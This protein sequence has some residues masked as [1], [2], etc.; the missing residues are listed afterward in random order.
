MRRKR[1]TKHQGKNNLFLNFSETGE[2]PD[3]LSM[4][5]SISSE[6]EDIG[7]LFEVIPDQESLL[8]LGEFLNLGLEEAALFSVLAE[9]SLQEDVT[10]DRLAAF[11]K[12]KGVRVLSL[13]EKIE[14]MES[15]FLI[16]RKLATEKRRQ[17]YRDISFTVPKNVMEAL[18]TGD[19]RL[20]ENHQKLSFTALLDLLKEAF[21]ERENDQIT[22]VQFLRE[23][24]DLLA[25]GR[26]LP[27]IQYLNAHLSKT[28]SKAL[29]LLLVL[30]KVSGR[31]DTPPEYFFGLLFP[32]LYDQIEFSRN[33]QNGR[34]ELVKTGVV[35]VIGSRNDNFQLVLGPGAYK[36]LFIDFPE[37][38]TSETG[39]DGLKPHKTI[40]EK[41]LYFNAEVNERIA[42]LEKLL[43]HEEFNRYK[44]SAARMGM[45]HGITT[46]FYGTPGTGKTELALQIARKTR[47]DLMMID[48]SQTRSMW[49]GESEKQVRRI[50]ENYR[51]ALKTSPAEPIL[52]INEADGLLSHRTD[53]GRGSHGVAHTQ[54]LIQN[55]LLEELENFRDI[56]IATTNLTG[57]LDK[58]FERRF[59]LKIDFPRPD[60]TVRKQIWLSKLPELSPA[61][62]ES[63][64]T[65]F[66]FSGGQIDNQVKQL[67]MK[68][69]LN[70]DIDLLQTLT[71]SCQN[72]QGFSDRK[73][74]GYQ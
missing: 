41:K 37:L 67:L 16:K 51:E 72:E 64:A 63:L 68:R 36:L 26:S 11:F 34:H 53:L 70:P 60:S 2:K 4:I 71:E 3:Y 40:K 24:E 54:N 69:I 30:F 12:C 9:L 5:A 57:N 13:L 18:R 35:K 65:Q 44:E 48:L 28:T 7:L 73:R 21:D 14:L 74:I 49:F 38:V 19:P 55:I 1:S 8:S 50:F 6:A 10:L 22:T 58:A 20:L 17:A 46:I 52:F 39:V 29:A 25:Q 56:L 43:N 59:L 15:R 23:V 32:K 47:R 27:F 31:T 61:M 66:D 62:A 33:L 45:N 42:E